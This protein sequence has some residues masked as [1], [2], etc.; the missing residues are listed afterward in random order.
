MSSSAKSTTRK[1]KKRAT[2]FLHASLIVL[3]AT[4]LAVWSTDFPAIAQSGA[5]AVTRDSLTTLPLSNEVPSVGDV[6]EAADETLVRPEAV[7]AEPPAEL[8]TS[9]T[10]L[11]TFKASAYC[12]K[13]HTASGIAVRRGMIA[14]DPRVLPLGSVVRIHAG[15]YS[16]I[17][18]VLD[19]GSAIRG[20]RVDIYFP[21]QAEA[22]RF[23]VREIKLEVLRNGWDPDRSL[24]ETKPSTNK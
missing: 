24:A 7:P 21:S 19:T 20:R 8:V 12:L 16:G 17:Y 4:V 23:G 10:P 13:G 22:I 1:K 15:K 18:T 2:T 9:Q 6:A 14:A 5:A 3:N 11:K